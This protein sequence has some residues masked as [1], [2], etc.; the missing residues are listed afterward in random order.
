MLERRVK[1]MKD[2]QDQLGQALTEEQQRRFESAMDTGDQALVDL[3]RELDISL[4]EKRNRERQMIDES[5]VSLEEGTYGRCVECGTHINEKRLAVMPF[6]RL[7]IECQEKAE[8]FE[9][10]ERGEQRI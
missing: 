8:L 7:C 9:K 4:Q 2:I 3:E 1:L 6:T 10:I 5:L